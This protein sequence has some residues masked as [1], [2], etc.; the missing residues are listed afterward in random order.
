M[1]VNHSLYI[2]PIHKK[3][4]IR[5]VQEI[6][7]NRIIDLPSSPGIY[8]F[9]WIGDRETLLNANRKMVLKGP[10]GKRVEIELLDWWPADLLFPCLYVG[11]TTNLKQRFSL[12]IKR[13]LKTR[14]HQISMS[15]EKV[16][17]KTTSCQLRY[18]IEHVFNGEQNPLLLI[19][20]NVGF[21]FETQGPANDVV[22]R[23]Y[24]EDKL[25]GLWRPWFNVDSER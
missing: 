23:F 14:L 20:K 25:I 16:K 15:G 10:G 9:W 3:A 2:I 5:S 19:E 6:T 22:E 24:L 18:G 8:A 17:P 4:R 13:G 21:S 12:H 11:K 1:E 7:A